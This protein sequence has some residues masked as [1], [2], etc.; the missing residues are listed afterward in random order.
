MTG[1]GPVE[2]KG[3][4]TA[5]GNNGDADYAGSAGLGGANGA[6]GTAGNPGRIVIT[7]TYPKVYYS[8][9]TSTA[10]L[11]SGSP[12]ITIASGTATFSAAQPDNIGV[13]DKIT[14]NTSSICYISARTSST[15]YT[16]VT[17]TGGTPADVT[18]QT[19]NS[20]KRTFNLISTAESSST[21]A[22]Y[23]NTADL[24]AGGYT[25]YWPC[26]NDGA[27]NDAVT[28]DGYTTGSNRFIQIYTPTATT[29]VGA[30][31]RH[32]GTAGTGFRLVPS[33]SSPGAAYALV[34][35]YDNYVRVTGI[36]VDGSSVT[37][38][39]DLYGIA[40]D[41]SVSTTSDIRVS[42]N[43]VHDLTTSAGTDSV[44]IGIV[45]GGGN[46]KASNNVVYDITNTR[47]LA[48]SYRAMGIRIA[49]A[50]T[51]HYLYNNTVFDIK[52]TGVASGGVANGIAQT[53][54]TV[55]ATNNVVFDVISTF[56]TESCF[57][58]T[59][60]QS[61][62]V[63]SDATASGTGSQT[64]KT[65]YTS[66]F[67]STTDGSE[68]LHV[69]SNSYTLWGSYGTDLDS[70]ANLPVT[71]DIDGVAR[72]G[73]QPSIGADEYTALTLKGSALQLKGS[74]LTLKGGT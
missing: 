9:G 57:S 65:S 41:T 72:D 32:T 61:Y 60:T 46:L 49:V 10:D 5:A 18:N 62:N 63:S 44:A 30:S 71:D 34:G 43:L 51:T 52:Q 39:Q 14:Y 69:L 54:G 42:H 36:E 2:T 66:Y 45:V 55:T 59:I 11:R 8:V 28:I 16:V 67:V 64:S 58:G 23:L 20:I 53:N 38:G 27:M 33:T 1:S 37:N 56:N 4:G 22:S 24:V 19:V 68:N 40:L 35:I 12:T 25:L 70:D 73:V 74:A 7:Y 21:G 29:E 3:T 31:Q 48:T 17:A 26:Y 50:S 13:G 47:D 6:T 15:V